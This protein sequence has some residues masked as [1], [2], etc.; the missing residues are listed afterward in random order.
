MKIGELYKKKWIEPFENQRNYP[1]F[2]YLD[3]Y[4]S[5]SYQKKNKT[6]HIGKD[7]VTGVWDFVTDSGETIEGMA[8]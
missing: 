7:F 5:I 6:A 1:F 4:N 2:V 3:F 8:N